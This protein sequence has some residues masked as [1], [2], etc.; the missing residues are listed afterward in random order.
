MEDLVLELTLIALVSSQRYDPGKLTEQSMY[1]NG[2]LWREMNENLWNETNM[3]MNEQY[4]MILMCPPRFPVIF[5][6]LLF[7]S[8]DKQCPELSCI[9]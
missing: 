1:V 2:N 6:T 9:P 7:R 8:S 5:S 3:K 4:L